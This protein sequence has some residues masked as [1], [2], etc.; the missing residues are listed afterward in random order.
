MMRRPRTR[1]IFLTQHSY[2]CQVFRVT[3]ISRT[4]VVVYGNVS[5]AL[6]FNR[7]R[8]MSVHAKNKTT[9]KETNMVVSR[10]GHYD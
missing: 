4:L 6:D 3:L 10:S 2:V 9:N 7:N 1:H 8:S 5:F